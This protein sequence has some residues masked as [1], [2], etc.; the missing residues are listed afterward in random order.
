[1]DQAHETSA[2]GDGNHAGGKHP[3][4]DVPALPRRPAFDHCHSDREQKGGQQG[5]DRVRHQFFCSFR[6]S[7]APDIA[8]TLNSPDIAS[9]VVPYSC[10]RPSTNELA[11]EKTRAIRYGPPARTFAKVPALKMN[12]VAESSPARSGA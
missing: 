7:R 3:D 11:F 10:N 2:A 9:R 6:R 4:A 5:E 1:M 8:S 12:A